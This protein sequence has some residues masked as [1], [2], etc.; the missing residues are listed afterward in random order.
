MQIRKSFKILIPA[1]LI[2]GTLAIAGCNRK[3]SS[4]G[5]EDYRAEEISPEITRYS[6]TV[7]LVSLDRDEKSIGFQNLETGLR[8]TLNYDETTVFEDRYEAGMSAAQLTTGPIADIEFEKSEKKLK[9]LRYADEYFTYNKVDDFKVYNG[10]TRMTFLSD[11]YVLDDYLVI[12]SGNE[13]MD[14]L[15]LQEGDV[16][17][18]YGKEHTIYSMSL[19]KGHGYL[20]LSGDN[21]FV[22]GFI[23][24]GTK[25]IRRISEGMLLTIPEG[26]YDILVS[27]DGAQGKK[28]V[29][30]GRNQE[31]T[32]DLSDIS[33]E[34]KYGQ[35]LFILNP[36]EASLY[37]DGEKVDAS[38]PIELE[39]GI[40]Q[41]ICRADGYV[42]KTN[43]INVASETASVTLSLEAGENSKSDEETASA[44]DTSEK[45]DKDDE[46]GKTDQNSDKGQDSSED[47]NKEDGTVDDGT[48]LVSDDAAVSD[49]EDSDT[50]TDTANTSAKVYID[51]PEGA[52]VY[53]DGN[54]VGIAP[55]SFAK[56]SGTIVVTLRKN[57]YR[58]RSY[59]INIEDD[60][61]SVRYSFSDLLEDK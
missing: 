38:V 31:V 36:S 25:I 30:V 1:V 23:E 44:K 12:A 49:G 39:Y 54:Y 14:V 32:L 22:G 57:G 5:E 13:T 52:E 2:L 10:E 35:I 9:S 42:T 46:K 37:I 16:L 7:I 15:E 29:T 34:K 17:T 43:Y 41:L 61:S 47:E 21:Y 45:T 59:T 28:H 50:D 11:K 20:R 24:V 27:N 58:T 48:G 26:E 55:V 33:V 3:E 51:A 8:Y 18:V 6:D 56:K 19:E 40:H 4:E 53:I 60:D